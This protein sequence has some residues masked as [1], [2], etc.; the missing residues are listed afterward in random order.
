MS[1][2]NMQNDK[3]VLVSFHVVLIQYFLTMLHLLLFGMV[4]HFLCHCILEGFD[5]LFNFDFI[6][7]SSKDILP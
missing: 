6:G 7:G 1:D 2:K 4:K 5:L 3:F